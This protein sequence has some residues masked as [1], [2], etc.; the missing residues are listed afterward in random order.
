MEK[1]IM[2]KNICK[3]ISKIIC[4]KEIFENRFNVPIKFQ[5][6]GTY[7]IN[8]RIIETVYTISNIDLFSKPKKILDFGCSRSWLSISLSSFTF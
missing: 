4:K 6:D 1:A 8:E 5:E 7:N 3:R 2:V